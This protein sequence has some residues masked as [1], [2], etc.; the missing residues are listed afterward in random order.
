MAKNTLN[1][2]RDT[3]LAVFAPGIEYKTVD[4]MRALSENIAAARKKAQTA[5]LAQLD[6]N[7][8]DEQ[9]SAALAS[10]EETALPDITKVRGVLRD[11]KNAGKLWRL[12]NTRATRFK[13][14]TPD[15]EV[16]PEAETEAD[17]ELELEVDQDQA[18]QGD[19]TSDP[20]AV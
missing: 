3:V 4:I 10:V 6:D 17:H 5:A 7:P 16:E 2:L 14:V 13:L 12:G 11:L 20:E 18:A 19:P 9:I 8:T 15:S 1:N